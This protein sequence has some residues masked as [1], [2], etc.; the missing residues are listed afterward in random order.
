MR[1]Y[2]ED[3]IS[4]VVAMQDPMSELFAIIRYLITD[5]HVSPL[6]VPVGFASLLGM[7]PMLDQGSLLHVACLVHAPF[8]WIRYLI[9]TC[10]C[11]VDTIMGSLSDSDAYSDSSSGSVGMNVF[12]VL[13]MAAIRAADAFKAI[14]QQENY[15]TDLWRYL[16]SRLSSS[17]E[18]CRLMNMEDTQGNTPLLILFSRIDAYEFHTYLI[19]SK[20]QAF[21]EMSPKERV[22]LVRHGLQLIKFLIEE[23]HADLMLPLR[24]REGKTVSD[25]YPDVMECFIVFIERKRNLAAVDTNCDKEDDKMLTKKP[26]T[27]G[28]T[29]S[30]Y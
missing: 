4:P 29:E 8:A 19:L 7:N 13:A 6:S 28:T 5:C 24:Y 14:E 18:Q 30:F 9:E 22:Q 3:S 11:A 21:Q 15:F 26:R 12:H 2:R 25:C 20:D 10:G 16:L 23:C 17:V 27:T 1:E